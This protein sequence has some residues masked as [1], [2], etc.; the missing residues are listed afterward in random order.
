MFDT[1]IAYAKK[2][3]KW[4]DSYAQAVLEEYQRFMH[5]RALDFG[6]SPTDPIDQ[7]WHIHIL[8]TENYYDYCM[9]KFGK[10]IHHSPDMSLD[11]KARQA[12]I[13]KTIKIYSQLYPSILYPEI[14]N[15]NTELINLNKCS[16]QLETIK[17]KIEYTWAIPS[18]VAPYKSKVLSISV[19][20]NMIFKDL[21]SFVAIKTSHPWEIKVY[22]TNSTF[23]SVYKSKIDNLRVSMDPFKKINASDFKHFIVELNQIDIESMK[24]C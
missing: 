17:I 23:T 5:I 24:Y 12:R 1:I 20:P 3:Y 22:P 2:Q 11:Q 13:R 19:T 10:F 8:Y 7:L 16:D 6:T 14:W 15:I 4:S 21:I 9:K 18:D